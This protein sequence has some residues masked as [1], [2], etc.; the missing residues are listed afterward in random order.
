MILMSALSQTVMACCFSRARVSAFRIAPP[1]V[2]STMGGPSSSRFMTR[3]S[4][5]RNS[6]SPSFAKMSETVMPGGLFDLVVAVG[7]RQAQP[8][9]QTPP[10]RGFSHAHQPDQGYGAVMTRGSIGIRLGAR[11]GITVR[12]S[13]R[14]APCRQTFH[15]S[16]SGEIMSGI[17]SSP[18]VEAFLEMMAVERDASP[19]T[20][21]AYARDLADAEAG[22]A[23]AG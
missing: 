14:C 15:Q 21:S 9:A 1:P 18:R 16:L 4:P 17:V 23:K 2:A 11:K 7:E 6:A 20:L 12:S 8:L 10:D 13:T 3:A 5:S 19:H 22:S